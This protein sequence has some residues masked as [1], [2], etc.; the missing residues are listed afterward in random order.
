MQE[1]KLARLFRALVKLVFLI[2][3]LQRTVE[4]E[5]HDG[6]VNFIFTTPDLKEKFAFAQF[7]HFDLILII[8]R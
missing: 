2:V 3:L 6:S 8:N 4:Y 7:L 5:R 1:P